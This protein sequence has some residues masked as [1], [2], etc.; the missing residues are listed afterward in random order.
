MR[1]GERGRI[2]VTQ[3]RAEGQT[4]ATTVA[5]APAARPAT[6]KGRDTRA[7]IM[8][9][10]ESL[11]AERGY[12]NVRVADIAGRA[13]LTTGAFYR[14][15]TDRHEL[16]L[17]LLRDLTVEIFEFI[18]V[19]LDADNLVDSVTESTQKY[20]DFYERHRAL[21]GVLVEL[22]QSDTEI[23]E[24]W[25]AS[26]RAFY[27]RISGALS[28]ASLGVAHPLRRQ[29]QPGR[30][31][32]R[33]YVA[34]S[35]PS[36]ASC[37]VTR[38]SRHS[39]SR[40]RAEHCATICA[41]PGFPLADRSSRFDAL[42][43]QHG[44]VHYRARCVYLS[45]YR[46]R[47]DGEVWRPIA[48]AHSGSSSRAFPA[49]ICSTIHDREQLSRGCSCLLSRRATSLS[50]CTIA[51]LFADSGQ[52]SHLGILVARPLFRSYAGRNSGEDRRILPHPLMTRS[53]LFS[54]PSP[55]LICATFALDSGLLGFP[56]AHQEIAGVLGSP[57]MCS[58]N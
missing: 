5:A 24:I 12:A 16:T 29:P 9:A 45:T 39:R 11:F 54:S 46:C 31:N 57:L 2:R 18:R 37:C 8:A 33:Q 26:R 48:L 38:T 42:A 40:R 35:T 22:A 44:G 32:A 19:P 36:N 58:S 10:A 49:T 52:G 30:G 28:R 47:G 51:P 13:G 50:E 6:P 41:G 1:T 14:Y 23:A 53:T 55:S 56:H 43:T 4:D 34:N 27:S 20:F 25:T 17:E 7:R 3:P 21:F 15:F